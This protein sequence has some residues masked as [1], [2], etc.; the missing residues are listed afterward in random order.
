M[1]RPLVSV[2]VITYNSA[3]TVI[4]TLDS[5]LNQT[6]SNIEL[7]ISDDCSTDNTIEICENWLNDN[8]A[9]FIRTTLIQSP[10]N[11]GISANC[12]RAEDACHGEWEK[13]LAGDDLL[14]P[15][16]IET[17]M[18]HIAGRTNS[19]CFFSRVQYFNAQKEEIID[20]PFFN[21]DFFTLSHEQQLHYLIY[22]W[23]CLPAASAFL[24]L[25]LLRNLGIRN[26]ERIPMMEDWP[27]WINILNAGYKLEFLDE[28]L[29]K[30]RVSDGISTT[31]ANPAFYFSGKMFTLLYLYPEWRKRDPDD[32]FYRLQVYMKDGEPSARERRNMRV[33]EFLLNPLY[34][35]KDIICSIRKQQNGE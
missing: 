31:K 9:S 1:E 17:Y 3:S 7:I 5:I 2:A 6:Y 30:Y 20:H 29:V 18:Q 34:K 23:N 4:E 27:K 32:A 12:N 14:L 22:E 24:N 15:Q 16:C 11:T 35:I 33:G 21:Y 19:L 8:Q 13:L 28:Q 10:I 25:R 26:D